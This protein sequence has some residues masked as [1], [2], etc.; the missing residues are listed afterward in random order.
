TASI[1]VFNTSGP[2]GGSQDYWLEVTNDA[3]CSSREYI[4]LVFEGPTFLYEFSN[5]IQIKVYPNP[6]GNDL[7][8]EL[9]II[10]KGQYIIEVFDCIGFPIIQEQRHLIPG[11]QKMKLDMNQIYPG[12]YI[13][14]VKSDGGQIGAKK[15]VKSNN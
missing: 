5:Y 6:F 3:G 2:G 13:L 11:K 15:I 12:V 14:S 4:T 1:D 9:D 10:E 7:N 8:I